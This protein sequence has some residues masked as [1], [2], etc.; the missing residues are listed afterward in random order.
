MKVSR[1]EKQSYL[2][3]ETYQPNIDKL[4][5]EI[6]PIDAQIAAVE[7]QFPALNP[8]RTASIQAPTTAIPAAA[9]APAP[10]A[11]TVQAPKITQAHFD[12]M[13]SGSIYT[14]NDGKRYRKP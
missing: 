12:A 8:N 5:S 1:A 4:K 13:P 10:A 2:D 7:Q 9:A 3:K 6:A 11:P 14:G